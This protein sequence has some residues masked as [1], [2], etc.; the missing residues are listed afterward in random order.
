MRTAIVGVG[1]RLAFLPPYSPNLNPIEQVFAKAKH[2]MRMAKAWCIDAIHE[3]NRLPLLV[4][5]TGQ[6]VQAVVEGW[7]I[8]R[9]PPDPALRAEFEAQAEAVGPEALHAELEAVDPQAA[10]KL[11]PRNVRRVIRALEVYLK[12]GRPI[13]ELQRRRPP[14]YQVLQVG[15]TMERAA[16]YQRIDQRVDRM[17]ERGL[18]EEVKG[19]LEQG[20]GYGLPAMSG[21]G[22]R[23]I[24][25]YLRGEI[26]LE[27]AIR[28]IKRDTRRF[29]RQQYNWFRLDDEGI[30][31]FQAL[32]D[33]YDRIKGVILQF[34]DY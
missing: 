2:W 5:G 25:C 9:V 15:L 33:P 6:W 32:D 18:V 30:R 16:L 28:L 14:P 24:G 31:W 17:I 1:A 12:T 22:Y 3:R 21:L 20:Y 23:Q 27:E 26:S 34:L 29:V 13:S 19:L 10:Q 4:G 8:P 11:D 7:G